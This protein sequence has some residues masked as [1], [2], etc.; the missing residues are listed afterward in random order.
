MSE[1]NTH[2]F[3]SCWSDEISLKFLFLLMKFLW[4][5][6]LGVITYHLSH[7]KKTGRMKYWEGKNLYLKT[8]FLS[9][10]PK[11]V[12]GDI[13]TP[14]PSSEQFLQHHW[15]KLIGWRIS[16]YFL[17][18]S[19]FSLLTHRSVWFISID[20]LTMGIYFL[21]FSSSFLNI[22][23]T[24]LSVSFVKVNLFSMLFFDIRSLRF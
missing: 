9:R 18:I 16:S 10:Q 19:F 5:L 3:L 14:S 2:S 23:F 24:S 1:L 17:F 15:T 7:F 22:L 12:K 13:L 11:E 20:S 8:V 4:K 21:P 6:H